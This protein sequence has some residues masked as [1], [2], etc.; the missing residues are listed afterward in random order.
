MAVKRAYTYKEQDKV[1]WWLQLL[2]L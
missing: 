1:Q 2:H